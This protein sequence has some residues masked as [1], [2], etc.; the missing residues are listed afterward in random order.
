MQTRDYAIKY[1]ALYN[2]IEIMLGNISEIGFNVDS[3]KEELKII[4]NSVSNNIKNNEVIDKAKKL[5]KDNRRE[6]II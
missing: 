4:N 6:V 1:K 3:Y 5:V 2:E